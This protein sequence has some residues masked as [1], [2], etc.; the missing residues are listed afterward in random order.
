MKNI[1]V[2][3]I[4]GVGGYFGGKI[5][6]A[7]EKSNNNDYNLYFIARGNH[8]KV[9]KKNGLI[10]N[11]SSQKGLICRPTLATDN[12]NEIPQPD[13]VILAVK[14]YDLESTLN[15]ISSKITENTIVL[16]LLNGVDIYERIRKKIK[17]GIILPSCVYVISHI[18]ETG[19]VTQNGGEG[20]IIIGSDTQHSYYYPDMLI[21][22]F[23]LFS[24]SFRWLENSQSAIWEKY[25][26]VA[27]YGLVTAYSNKPIGEVFYDYDLKEKTRQIMLEIFNIGKSKGIKLSDGLVE[28]SLTRARLI[29]H[30]TK[31]SY[32]RDIE[33]KAKHN[34]GDIFGEA[35][36]RMSEETGVQAPVTREIYNQIMKQFNLR[37]TLA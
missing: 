35:I 10:L 25:I 37:C 9:I 29:P 13:I 7:I 28:D 12:F 34:E 5:A 32:Q 30:T 2:I 15:K 4:G 23:K 27:A 11:T 21:E 22:A 1:A 18:E 36:I 19:I 16:P 24:I 6:N 8:L 3:G 31:T 26:F 33:T 20:H 14:S 17:N